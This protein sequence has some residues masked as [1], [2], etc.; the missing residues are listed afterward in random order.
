MKV[1]VRDGGCFCF[2][3]MQSCDDDDIGSTTLE[4]VRHK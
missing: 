2:W 3:N 1:F 4:E